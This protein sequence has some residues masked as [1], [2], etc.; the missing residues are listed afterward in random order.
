MRYAYIEQNE[1]YYN[2]YGD[3]Y[4]LLFDG[5]YKIGIKQYIHD[6]I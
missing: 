1:R 6:T 2:Y 3:T 5:V 4:P